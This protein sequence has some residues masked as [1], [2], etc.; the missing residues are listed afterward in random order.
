MRA[1]IGD[2]GCV[3]YCRSSAH[4][5]GDD[6]WPYAYNRHDVA[7]RKLRGKQFVDQLLG[8]RLAG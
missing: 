5:R 8:H 1:L 2:G 6:H 4:Q 7:V 3:P